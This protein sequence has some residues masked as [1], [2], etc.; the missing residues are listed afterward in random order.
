MSVKIYPMNTGFIKL[1]KGVYIT[2][3][4]GY[5]EEVEVPTWA[6]L[7]TD[8][9]EKILVDTGMSDTKS[10]DWHHPGSY[11]PEE[12]RIDRQLAKSSIGVEEINAV[13]FTHLHWDHCANMKLFVNAQYFVHA[14]ELKFALDPHILYYKSYSSRKLGAIP[15]FDGVE[16]QTVDA[17]YEYNSFITFFPTPGHCPG[18]QSVEVKTDGGIYIIAGDAVFADENL[19]PDTRRKL[20]F[21]PMGRFVNVFELY[22][23]MERIIERADHVLTGHGLAVGG[24]PVYP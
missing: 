6:F 24:Q 20:P 11:Q 2:G 9:K 23:S 22:D 17:E 3:G 5:G 13:I 1:D 8:G 14:N 21:T 15:P 18:H 4:V 7:V 19:E 10:A 12:L 16:F